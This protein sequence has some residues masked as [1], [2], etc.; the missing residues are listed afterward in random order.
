MVD[1]RAG[2][3]ARDRHAQAN[4]DGRP[5]LPEVAL[6]ALEG[7]D[8]AAFEHPRRLEVDVDV[9]GM[10]DVLEPTAHE[11]LGLVA[12]DLRERAVHADPAAVAAADDHPDGRRVEGLQQVVADS[13]QRLRSRG[14]AVALLAA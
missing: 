4:E 3:I 11:L 6:D 1:G 2:A 8:L 10:R 14:S 12:Y 7:V 9:Q 13:G 5:V